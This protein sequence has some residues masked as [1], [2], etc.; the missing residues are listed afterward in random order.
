MTRLGFDPREIELDWRKPDLEKELNLLLREM[1]SCIS[2][3][4]KYN[5]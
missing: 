1:E 4:D 3:L 5:P 2:A